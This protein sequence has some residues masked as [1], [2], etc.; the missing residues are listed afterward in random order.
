VHSKHFKLLYSLRF[1][2]FFHLIFFKVFQ[3]EKIQFTFL[4]NYYQTHFSSII[5]QNIHLLPA[6]FFTKRLLIFIV[7]Y[8]FCFQGFRTIIISL[9][10]LA[11]V[12]Y[13][14]AF[15][16]TRVLYIEHFEV[17]IPDFN[18]VYHDSQFYLLCNCNFLLFYF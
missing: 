15:F 14:Q 11:A 17:I 12:V 10:L 7:I 16:L 18:Q 3:E 1:H 4:N 13:F 5:N 8:S 2:Y 6:L 9:A